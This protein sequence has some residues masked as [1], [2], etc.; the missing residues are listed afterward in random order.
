MA[1]SPSSYGAEIA[2]TI[3]GHWTEIFK[4]V[5][6]HRNAER[7]RPIWVVRKAT[8]N[9]PF[10]EKNPKYIKKQFDQYKNGCEY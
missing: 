7:Y 10:F 5:N 3:I 2:V 9:S 6:C 8:H 1:I 4:K